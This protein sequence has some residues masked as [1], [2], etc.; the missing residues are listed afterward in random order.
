MLQYFFKRVLRM[1]EPTAIHPAGQAHNLRIEDA[2]PD[3]ERPTGEFLAQI[4]RSAL[5]QNHAERRGG[6]TMQQFPEDPP[7]NPA[8]QDGGQSDGKVVWLTS[9]RPVTE[10]T[11]NPP[12]HDEDNDPGPSAA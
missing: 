2:N 8:P 1:T 5:A 9:R 4:L 7:P 11:P 3:S 12:A 6:R 10:Q